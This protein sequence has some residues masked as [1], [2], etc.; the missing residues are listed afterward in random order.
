MSRILL[1]SGGADYIDPWHPFAE[2]SAMVASILEKD[3]H[4]LTVVDTLDGLSE[5]LGTVDLLV[6]NAGG[7]P[8][9]HS[10][11]DRLASILAGYRGPLLALH[12]AATLLPEHNAWEDSLGG[13]WV[14]GVSMHPR[15]GHLRLRPVP[16]SIAVDDLTPLETVDE[17]YSWLRV[18]P[19]AEILLVHDY[20]GK[21][22]PVSW[23][24]NRDGR[25]TAYTA[26]G[27][28]SDAYEAPLAG[29][30]LRLLVNWLCAGAADSDFRYPDLPHAPKNERREINDN[31][32]QNLK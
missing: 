7:G 26:L 25:R 12:V 8:E 15:R 6:V 30:L 22:H 27:H 9:P 29:K 10:L 23:T 20:E 13:R 16:S 18:M 2:T 24:L 5:A 21:A 32:N 4:K 31:D 17:A 28:D 11:D 1:F 14:R 3:G 19:E